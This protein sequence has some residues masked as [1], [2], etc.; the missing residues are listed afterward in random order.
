MSQVAEFNRDAQF[1]V[2]RLQGKGL[3][4]MQSGQHRMTV[5]KS[6]KTNV[7]DQWWIVT[8]YTKVYANSVVLL[9]IELSKFGKQALRRNERSHQVAETE[10][11]TWLQIARIDDDLAKT[12]S[13]SEKEYA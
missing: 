3:V 13:E 7:K 6:L 10:A 4:E 5:L 9:I 11:D 12:T 8:I 2:V 1:P